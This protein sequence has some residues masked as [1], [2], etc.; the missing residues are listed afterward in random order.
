GE[1][2]SAAHPEAAKLARAHRALEL[3]AALAGIQDQDQLLE[4]LA[5]DLF[6]MFGVERVVVLLR[7][8]QLRTFT[9]GLARTRDGAPIEALNLSRTLM[10]KVIGERLSLVT[11]DV[12]LD[13]RFVP[14]G[15]LLASGTRSA[16]VSPL[17]CG[18]EVLG[19]VWSD[20][21]SDARTFDE[22]DLPIFSGLVGVAGVSLANARLC[23]R[24]ATEARARSHLSRY[25]SPELVQQVMD[26][27]VS[28]Q[29]GG[30]L[31]DATVLFCDMRG[32]T[33]A[34]EKASP[35]Q[36]VQML[37]RYFGRMVEVVFRNGGTVDKFIGDAIMA[38]WGVPQ[39]RPTD[40]FAAVRAGIEMQRELADYNRES[41]ALGLP[42][43]AMGVGIHSGPVVAGNIGSPRR[44][45]FTVIGDTVNTASRVE[46][47]TGA[48]D[49]FLTKETLGRLGRPIPVKALPPIKVK[50][51]AVP[52]ELFAVDF[53]QLVRTPD[54][55]TTGKILVPK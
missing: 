23:Q 49:V 50:N 55:L 10:R 30:S 22:G 33:A 35:E 32:F 54:R 24:V 19:L 15:S 39:A 40:A 26:Q 2:L 8:P 43:V 16:L 53:G 47:S 7:E 5:R 9:V 46:S 37:N 41:L 1:E 38:V 42:E 36:V 6:E 29:M 18:E 31:A 12:S 52:L 34:S 28:M 45:E 20:T 21:V 27:K 17:L 3:T 4:S 48:G 44:M 51:K 25:L 13:G 11:S 14:S